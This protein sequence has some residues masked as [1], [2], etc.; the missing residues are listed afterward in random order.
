M[1]YN[2]TTGVNAATTASPGDLIR[3]R[4][5]IENISGTMVNGFSLVDELDDLN[6]PAAFVP[7]SLS[8][9]SAPADA[10]TSNTNPTGGAAGTGL[11]DVRN[12]NLG[13]PGGTIT[14]EFDAQR[15]LAR[16][17]RRFEPQ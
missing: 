5:V 12:L 11:L 9:F 8:I 17:R 10:D 7:G 1:A 14:I 4:I 15:C 13:G 6:A 2:L 3:Y 16:E